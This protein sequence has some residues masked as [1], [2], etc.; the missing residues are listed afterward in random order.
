MWDRL[1][2][3][4]LGSL[5]L[6]VT[7]L[8][9]AHVILN[10]RDVRAAIGWTGLILFNPF[11]GALAYYVLGINRIQRRGAALTLDRSEGETH[12]GAAPVCPVDELRATHGEG[13]AQL[14]HM[15]DAI[16]CLP[17]VHGNLVEPL[18]NGDRAYPDML[19]AIR[20]ARRSVALETYIFDADRAGER[21]VDALEEAARRGV[22]VRV[23]VDGVGKRYGRPPITRVLARR[24]VAVREFLPTRIPWRGVY[25]NLRNHRK[26]LVVDGRKAFVGGLNVREGNLIE[27]RPRHPVQDLHFH[28]EGPVVRQ[29]FA[30]LAQ[31]WFFA[32]GERLEGPT[33][34][35][36]E[37]PR[38]KVAARAVP[39]GPDED[40]ETI[41]W[42]LLAALGCARRSVRIVTPYFLPAPP[43]ITQL[44][45]AALRGIEVD[46]LL[47][48]RNNLRYVQWASTA[49][50]WQVLEPGCR[51]WLTPPPF[52]HSKLMVVDESW[53]LIGSANWDERSLRLNFELDVECYDREL[54]V[55]LVR[56]IDEKK[57]AARRVTLADVD[58]RPLP[59]RL[60]DGVARLFAP[61]L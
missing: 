56:I 49:Q 27:E 24:G 52:D 38:G 45:L 29:L 17:L 54:A 43:L 30:A 39:D 18:V 12:P 50:L 9:A 7:L 55:A 41:R 8:A 44:R 2:P 48:A 6:A 19:D 57:R 23:L 15:V 37:E 36:T 35:T 1:W 53:S 34:A 59:I 26:L 5:T 14:G 61:Y 40:F 60:R 10:K 33:W 58:G 28:V 3:W 46:I 47:P 51:V 20:S 31:D 13:L 16:T 25:M 4:L 21:F 42:T 11:V 32:T 22:E